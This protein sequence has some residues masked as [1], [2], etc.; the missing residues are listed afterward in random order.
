MAGIVLLIGLGVWYVKFRKDNAPQYLTAPVTRGDLTQLVTAAGQLNPVTNVTVG[1][2]ISGTIAKL[3]ADFNSPVTNGQV[4]A[5]IDPRIYQANL[6]SAEGD[7]AN[8]EAALELARVN[9]GR[10]KELLANRLI[11]QSD[12]DQ[13]VATLHQAEAT[14]QIKSASV[15]L[16]KAN[17]QYCTIYSPVDGMVISR[18]V[19][20][21]Q[22]VAASLN[23]PTL[24]VIA[25]DLAKMQI[26]ANV[27][28]SDVGGVEVGQNVDFTVDAF[29]NRTFHGKV[30]QVRNSPIT[31]Q[32]VVTYDTVIGV[33]NADLKLKPG[34][35][36]NVSV[37]VAERSNVLRVPNAALRFH[38]PESTTNAVPKVAA[39]AAGS[40]GSGGS[41]G[42]HG[43]GEHRPT[44]TIYTLKDGK[45]EPVQAKTG[46][47]DGIYTEIT[48]GLSE[49][50]NV[51]TFASFKQGGASAQANNPFGMRRF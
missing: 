42:Q 8:A 26:D 21:G 22:T 47:T 23:A 27:A 15:E 20:V 13:A 50:N 33:S 19:D 25:N 10:S 3:Y 29:P 17:L 32:N 28:E 11:P 39:G 2:Q 46:I 43:K 41:S 4:V 45:L 48:D 37:I 31:V 16:A 18:N 9:A 38:P 6:H 24:F 12:D 34:M 36:A 49:S 40:P 5:E 7:F 51:V 44:R 30:V 35:T 14:V 1:C